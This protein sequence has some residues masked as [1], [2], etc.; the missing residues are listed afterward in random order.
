MKSQ[1]Q[2]C[3]E[4]TADMMHMVKDGPSTSF[5]PVES[6]QIFE[7]C[8]AQQSWVLYNIA[9]SDVP[10]RI[11]DPLRPRL[12][13]L[14]L[15][16]TQDELR[17]HAEACSAKQPGC[18]LFAAPVH[19]YRAM[20]SCLKWQGER[21]HVEA[22]KL[23]YSR[24]MQQAR[25]EFEE[26]RAAAQTATPDENAIDASEQGTGMELEPISRD[27]MQVEPEPELQDT[28]QITPLAHYD[29]RMPIAEQNYV[30][31]VV[32]PDSDE[33]CKQPVF[34]I[35]QAFASCEDADAYVKNCA[36][37]VID[38]RDIHVAPM[39]KWLDVCAEGKKMEYRDSA[40]QKIMAEQRRKVQQMQTYRETG[41]LIL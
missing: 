6:S 3:A 13:V 23:T 32:L 7:F 35:L 34:Q 27:A 30:A 14:G 8:S 9:H 22:V 21:E 39:Y 10:P 12:R 15:F 19:E 38:D 28:C 20:S 1:P 40:L 36:S 11:N 16:A 37:H 26:R 31:L 29:Y 17:E 2:I 25:A 4:R 41:K 33:T 24:N 18:A 5:D